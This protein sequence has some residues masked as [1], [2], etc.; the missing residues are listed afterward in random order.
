MDAQDTSP[1]D[2]QDADKGRAGIQSIEVGFRLLQVLAAQPRA[3]MLRD[4]AAAAEMNPAKAHRYLVSFGRLGLVAQDPISGR[5]DL[6]AFSL[7]LGLAGLNRLDPIKKARPMLSALCDEIDQTV[8]IAVWGNRGPTIVHWEESGQPVT[9]N[10]RLGDVM[11]LL[12]SATGRLFAA[13]LPKSHTQALLKQELAQHRATE[14][15]AIPANLKAYETMLEDV[16][17]HQGAR[18]EGGLLPGIVAFSLPVFDASGALCM[19]L[20]ALGSQG[21]MDD[22]WGGRVEAPLR[23]R[24]AQIS[25]E[26]GY[27]VTAA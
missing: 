2:T 25:A 19:A 11:P 5:Y 3:M 8:G 27:T 1:P 9:V 18:I 21:V 23:Q 13:Y 16:R 20:I 17:K 14:N 10:L 26:L 24:A 4:L 7:Q 22:R 6:G 15:P 12:N